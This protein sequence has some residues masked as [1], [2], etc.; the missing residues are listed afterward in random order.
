MEA[1]ILIKIDFQSDLSITEQVYEQ[2]HQQIICGDLKPGDQLPTVRQLAVDLK[3][4]FN[5]VA[6]VY[7]LLDKAG[8]ISTQHGRGTYILPAKDPVYRERIEKLDQETKIYLDK[9][10][11]IGASEA[12]ILAVIHRQLAAWKKGSSQN[13]NQKE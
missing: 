10:Q 8:L 5:T 3:V 11:K 6:R 9:T 13:K 1:D 12:E 4:N 7:R 2:I